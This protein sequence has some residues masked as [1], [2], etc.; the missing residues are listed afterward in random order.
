MKQPR[1]LPIQP[2]DAGRRRWLA[3]AAGL[4][5]AAALVPRPA[6]AARI[7]TRAHV[8]IAG[9]G[10]G[11]IAVANRL[12]AALDGVRITIVDRKEEH[13]YQPGY[14]L[15]ATGVWPVSKVRDRN[16]D[17][18]PE[19][20]EWVRDMVA[21]FD[22]A[23][24]SVVTAGG[25]RIGY[26]YLVVATGVHLDYAQIEG[27]DVAAI[28]RHGLAS[29]YNGPQAAEATWGAM[30]EFAERGGEALM[31]LPATPLKCAGAP[32]KTTFMLR[33]RLRQAGTLERSR[34][35]FMSA[36]KNVFGVKPVND[37]VLERWQQLGIGVE[38]EQ[39]LVAVDIG[40][41]RASFVGADGS[42]AERGYD[43]LHVVP[44]MRAPDVVRHS[45]LAWKDGPF[46]AGGWL[47]VDKTTLRHRRYA[48]VF[49]VGDIN[50]TPRGKTA[51]TV[52]KSAPVVVHNLVQLIA[53]AEPDAAFDGYTS[54]PL[55]T[56]EG[57]AML[58]EFDYEGR[59]TPSLPMIE[60]LQDSYFA[61][62]MKVRLLKP[63]YLSVLKGRV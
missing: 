61:W 23:S 11:G 53:G 41:R 58:I 42:R 35:S 26:D 9:S 4:P 49:G 6:T 46:A 48:N 27:M 10:L 16:A 3:A 24:N 38:T 52:K 39:K 8:V 5:A 36:P 25:Q 17:F 15:V 57:S 55:I 14:T 34:V 44:P 28:G 13:N 20:V 56:R 30:R 33:D 32:L 63:A 40:A 45:D 50:G 59:L 31:T 18:H 47:E 1:N 12:S 60:P 43:F 2:P 37:N 29:V 21:E 54:C 51:A 19:G 22:P 7:P 62:L